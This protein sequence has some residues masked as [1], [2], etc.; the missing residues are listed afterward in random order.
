MSQKSTPVKKDEAVRRLRDAGF[1][2]E[3]DQLDAWRDIN[4]KNMGWD[5]WIRRSHPHVVPKIWGWDC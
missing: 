4:G 1:A 3:A 5:G 2:L